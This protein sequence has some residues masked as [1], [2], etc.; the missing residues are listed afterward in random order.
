M[1]QETSLAGA[2]AA[3]DVRRGSLKRVASVG[4]RSIAAHLAHLRLAELAQPAP[5]AHTGQTS[6][7]SSP[8]A[9]K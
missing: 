5:R 6:T 1:L 9:T 2:F 8:D 4:S 3:D 7:I